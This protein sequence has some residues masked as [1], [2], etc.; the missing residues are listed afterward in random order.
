MTESKELEGD[1]VFE[2]PGLDPMLLRAQPARIIRQSLSE[3]AA[4][5]IKS[6]ILSL[7]FPPGMRLVVDSLAE[8]LGV[9]RTP[10]REGL[11]ALVSQGIVTYNG[12]SYAVTAYSRQDVENLFAIRRALEALAAFQAAQR[13]PAKAL[14]DLRS[15]CEEGKQH[16]DA[17]DTELLITLDLRFHEL[18]ADGSG[19]ERLVRLLDNLREQSWLIRRWGF[20]P[21]LVAQKAKLL[22]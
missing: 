22:T 13:M 10:V 18:I 19:N 20:L 4:D 17:E 9:S 15:L 3:Q 12:N 2:L 1:N 8:E 21:K 11:K 7:D 14:D 6:R 16:I 5:A